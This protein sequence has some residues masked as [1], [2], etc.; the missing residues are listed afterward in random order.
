[1]KQL[2]KI[3]ITAAVAL[4]ITVPQAFLLAQEGGDLGIQSSG[5]LPSNPFYFLKEWG[6]GFRKLLSA[7]ASNRAQ[8]ELNVLNEKAAELKKLEEIATGNLF[9]IDRALDSYLDSLSRLM[10]NLEAIK[11]ELGSSKLSAISED[12]I[13]QGLR[14]FRL[15]EDLSNKYSNEKASLEKI[16]KAVDSLAA[17]L[18]QAPIRLVNPRDFK[19]QFLLEVQELNDPFRELRA[20]DL[21][22]RLGEAL[23]G[24]AEKSVSFLREDLL[25]KFGGKLEGLVLAGGELGDLSGLSGDRLR[26]LRLIDEVREKVLTSALRNE[27]NIIRQR[28]LS[29]IEDAGGI[30]EERAKQAMAEAQ[31]LLARVEEMISERVSV[32]N[33]PKELVERAKFGLLQAEKFLEEGNY[34]GA[35]GQATAAQAALKNAINQLNPDISDAESDLENINKVYDFWLSEVNKSDFTKEQNPKL[36]SLLSEAERRIVALAK[37]IEREE[38]PESIAASLRTVKILLS[39]IEE[40]FRALENPK[41][42]EVPKALNSVPANEAIGHVPIKTTSVLQPESITVFI[43]TTGFEPP[44]I[45]VAAGA[46]VTWLNKDIRPH[47]PASASHPTHLVLPGFDSLGGLS[48]GES[49]SFVFEKA[50]SWKYHDHLNPGM[51]G[52]VEVSE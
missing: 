27:L 4:S 29:K 8:L 21:A 23:S 48:E 10:E 14:H 47:W 30:S 32:K 19:A 43:T 28:I 35:F 20:A 9:A 24:E 37:S 16:E 46:K 17:A 52:A 36:F 5:L 2:H 25:L 33:A 39:T 34:G 7:S 12:L 31:D 50:G 45:Q 49:Y 26:R 11:D 44:M 15:L 42:I 41:S 40:F 13:S 18:A 1:M 51:G 3:L 6:R 22:D 38:A